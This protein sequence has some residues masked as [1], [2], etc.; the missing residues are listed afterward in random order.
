M[1]AIFEAE[2]QKPATRCK[3]REGLEALRHRLVCGLMEEMHRNCLLAEHELTLCKSVA[4]SQSLELAD[5]NAKVLLAGETNI[6]QIS[7]G[8]AHH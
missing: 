3:F 1:V 4:V 2:L 5:Q 7:H 8:R 6:H